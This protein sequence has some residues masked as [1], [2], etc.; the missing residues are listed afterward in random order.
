MKKTILLLAITAMVIGCS[1]NKNVVS[2]TTEEQAIDSMYAY[3]PIKIGY[4][5]L[6]ELAAMPIQDAHDILTNDGWQGFNF[7]DVNNYKY[8]NYCKYVKY[9]VMYAVTF[10]A[11]NDTVSEIEFDIMPKSSSLISYEY[12]RDA[13]VEISSEI[14]FNGYQLHYDYSGNEAKSMEEAIAAIGNGSS[15]Y[16]INWYGEDKMNSFHVAIAS[17]GNDKYAATV[18]LKVYVPGVTRS[19]A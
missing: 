14:T 3:A 12:I 7:N 19:A 10:V 6:Q 18:S 1:K 9:D 13:V 4:E 8:R 5:L 2:T 17:D 16:T 11:I 15:W